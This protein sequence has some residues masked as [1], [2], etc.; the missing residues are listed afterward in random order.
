[1]QLIIAI[2]CGAGIGGGVSFLLLDDE[3]RQPKLA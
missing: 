2:A 1:M 3:V